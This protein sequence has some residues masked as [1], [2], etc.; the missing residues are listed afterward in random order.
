MFD[1]KSRYVK[2]A[3]L[4]TTVDARGREVTAVTPAAIPERP[5]L[6]DHQLKDG[7][8][9][10]HLAQFY[11]DDANGFWRIAAHSGTA[12]PDSVTAAPLEGVPV[13]RIPRRV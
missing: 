10:D 8:R 1:I 12:L 7:Q 13:V 3:T 2:F 5:H 11:L 9:L 6:G 4:Y